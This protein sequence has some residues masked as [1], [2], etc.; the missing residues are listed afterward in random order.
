[1][2]ILLYQNKNMRKL[3]HLGEKKICLICDDSVDQLDVD[4][5]CKIDYS[6][7]YGEAV[8]CPAL[9][10]RIGQIRADA[11]G[12]YSEAKMELSIYE[13]SLKKKYR[14]EAVL[15]K[16]KVNIEKGVEIKLSEG[17]LEDLVFCDKGYQELH[18]KVIE[19]KKD[20]DYVESFY[21]SLS[22]KDK[23]LNNMLPRL[24]PEEFFENILE[25]T[26]NTYT[27]KKI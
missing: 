14:R 19:S 18:K 10:N 3:I 20:W 26:V 22:S 15:L 25:G 6:N 11:E 2:Y 9:L 21:W 23:K 1:M 16:G 5:L 4:E 24:T 13:A 27:I 17:T 7:L 12:F 8:T